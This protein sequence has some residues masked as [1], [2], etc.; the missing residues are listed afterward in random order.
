MRP[1]LSINWTV[2]FCYACLVGQCASFARSVTGQSYM[3][4]IFIFDLRSF[5]LILFL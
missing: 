3:N 4:G 1:D 2:Y 5:L